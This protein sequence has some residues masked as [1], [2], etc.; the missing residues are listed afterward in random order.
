MNNKN[1]NNDSQS[2]GYFFNNIVVA[3][4]VRNCGKNIMGDIDRLNM[5]LQGCDNLKYLIIESDSMD[6]TLEKLEFLNNSISDFHYISLGVLRTNIP[7]RTERLAFC[8]NKYLEEIESNPLYRDIQY[9]LVTDLDG[10]N[11]LLTKENIASCL[12]IDDWDVCTANQKG[13]YYDIWALRHPELSPN[14]CWKAYH[15][16]VDELGI[17]PEIAGQKVLKSRML[18][19]KKN[20]KPFEV[21]SAFGGLAIYRRNILENIRYSGIDENGAEVCEHVALNRQIKEKGGKIYLNPRLINC[22]PPMQYVKSKPK[23]V[24]LTLKHYYYDMVEN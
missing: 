5:A 23:K 9:V 4:I 8:R 15:Y 18:W 10:T 24:L 12:Q 3:G 17:K 6:D 1:E 2:A 11:E 22:Y 13:P 21:D 7:K 20:V 14:D 16:M 19:F